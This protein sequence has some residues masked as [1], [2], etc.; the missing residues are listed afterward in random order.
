MSNNHKISEHLNSPIIKP[1]SYFGKF[2]IRLLFDYAKLFGWKKTIT[3]VITRIFPKKEYKHTPSTY[4]MVTSALEIR[5]SIERNLSEIANLDIFVSVIIPTYNAGPEFIN[6]LKILR[7]QEGVK[8]IE[9]VIVDSGSKDDTLQ[10][11]ESFNVKVV[12]TPTEK[13]THSYARNLG[14]KN[15]TGDYYLFT[16]QDAFPPNTTWIYDML[17]VIINNDVAAVSCAELPREN[18]DLFYRLLSWN[19]Y[20][21]LGI[22]ENDRIFSMPQK[23]DYISLRKNAQLSNLACLINGDI[24]NQFRYRRDYAEDLDLGL[25]LIQAGKKIAFMGSIRV[26]HSH[27]RPPFYFLKRGFVDNIF[28]AEMFSDF[29]IPKI[30]LCKLIPELVFTYHL[31]INV[32][33]QLSLIGLPIKTSEFSTMLRNQFSK[34]RSGPYPTTMPLLDEKYLDKESNVFLNNLMSGWGQINAGKPYFG[35]FLPAFL[36]YVNIMLMY[37]ISTYEFVY[38]DLLEDIKA[39]FFKVFCILTGNYLA[40]CYLNKT[41]EDEE[42]LERLKVLLIEGV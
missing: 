38:L 8:K 6:L 19:H 41:Y 21:F 7:K 25:R 24:F 33:D 28:L 31:L 36:E 20:K 34:A 30:T 18:A 29:S 17:Q 11:A 27:S 4:A 10:I 9:I 13:F 5:S 12:K 22:N 35:S 32:L 1:P 42:Q 2:S 40:Y 23:P 16:V 39:C 3:K 15:A 26:I 37:L 14:A